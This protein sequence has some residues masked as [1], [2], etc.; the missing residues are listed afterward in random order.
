MYA[1]AS[2]K[3]LSC[4]TNSFIHIHSKWSNRTWTEFQNAHSAARNHFDVNVN[5]YVCTFYDNSDWSLNLNGRIIVD[6]V[7]CCRFF[8]VRVCVFGMKR[9]A[10]NLLSSVGLDFYFSRFFSS[11]LQLVW[12]R[13]INFVCMCRT[14]HIRWCVALRR[15][16]KILNVSKRL[17]GVRVSRYVHNFPANECLQCETYLSFSDV[18]H[19]PRYRY[20][21]V[22]GVC[23]VHTSYKCLFAPAVHLIHAALN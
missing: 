4:M 5:S 15:N 6:F 3:T 17:N 16:A 21:V 18:E 9:T 19:F 7:C 10:S 22:H 13:K 23:S 8:F 1:H 20:G 12:F 11:C 2:S 14:Y